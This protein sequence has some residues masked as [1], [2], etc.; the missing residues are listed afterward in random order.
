VI[1]RLPLIMLVASTALIA[2]RARGAD[3]IE[4]VYL[5][6]GKAAICPDKAM[7][8]Q[9]VGKRLGYQPFFAAAETKL[10]AEISSRGNVLHARATLVDKTGVVRGDRQLSAPLSECG[11]L[12]ASLALA[13]SITLDPMS[14]V[15]NNAA[16]PAE[17]ASPP[18]TPPTERTEDRVQPPAAGTRDPNGSQAVAP[19][20]SLVER[21]NSTAEQMATDQV[22]PEGGLHLHASVGVSA[23]VGA[24]PGPSPGFRIG[25]EALRGLA[26]LSIEFT[27]TPV[28]S[29]AGPAGG[30][31]DMSLLF[32]SVVPCAMF[33]RLGACAVMSVGRWQGEGRNVD[34]ARIESHFYAAAGLRLIALV[35]LTGFLQLRLHAGS[36]AT[37]TRPSFEL[38][39]T[40]VWRPPLLSA[41]AGAALALYFL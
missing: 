10:V 31:A 19:S 24:L 30:D 29:Q 39:G 6:S 37:M 22:S 41:E 2:A 4:L 20:S 15:S 3:P 32:G 12:I 13:I 35:P 27:A 26:A 28:V 40:E 14:I 36:G 1:R 7:L 38:A 23:M 21:S 18:P 17:N 11:E 9:A 25:L 5:R 16:L 34:A 33:G 8:A